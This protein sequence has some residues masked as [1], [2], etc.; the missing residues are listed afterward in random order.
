M[1]CE[2]KLHLAEITTLGQTSNGN[3][4]AFYIIGLKF[5]VNLRLFGHCKH[6][7]ECK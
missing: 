1:N 6:N 3:K 4:F 5:V 2:A 7:R